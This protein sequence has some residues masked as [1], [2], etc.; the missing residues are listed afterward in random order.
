LWDA[1]GTDL[2]RALYF[3]RILGIF[4]PV[5]AWGIGNIF[6]SPHPPLTSPYFILLY[7]NKPLLKH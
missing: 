7:E 2:M 1:F 6:L 3:K 5:S 4:A